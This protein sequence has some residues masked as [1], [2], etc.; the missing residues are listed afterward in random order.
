MEIGPE[1]GEASEDEGVEGGNGRDGEG[2]SGVAAVFD[3]DGENEQG[4]EGDAEGDEQR[5]RDG[6]VVGEALDWLTRGGMLRFDHRESRI[7]PDWVL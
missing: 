7:G 4:H 6:G 3:D 1:P 2:E 5:E